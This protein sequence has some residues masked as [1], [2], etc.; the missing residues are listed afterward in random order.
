M[1]EY[2]DP[3]QLGYQANMGVD[4]AILYLLHRVHSHLETAG[5]TLRLMFCDFLSAFNTIQPVR[6]REKMLAT[7]VDGPLVTWT[8]DY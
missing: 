3:L 6:L 7:Q 8:T 4:D 5:S 1:K 2:Q